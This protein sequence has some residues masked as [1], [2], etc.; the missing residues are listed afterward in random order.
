MQLIAAPQAPLAR[1]CFLRLSDRARNFDNLEVR[2]T[3]STGDHETA[4]S[5][6][7]PRSVA[8]RP[9]WRR[10]EATILDV[11]NGTLATTGNQSDGNEGSTS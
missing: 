2:P 6:T 11:E 4:R 1:F 9:Q 8:D 7:E 10:P 5:A 3:V